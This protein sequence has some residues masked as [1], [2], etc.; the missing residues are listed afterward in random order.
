MPVCYLLRACTHA[1]TYRSCHLRCNVFHNLYLCHLRIMGAIVTFACRNWI[2]A[3]APHQ[4]C[5]LRVIFEVIP[6]VKL[7]VRRRVKRI[8][9]RSSQLKRS[10]LVVRIVQPVLL[11]C[12]SSEIAFAIFFLELPP[13]NGICCHRVPR[14]ILNSVYLAPKVSL[15]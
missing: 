1:R 2:V 5:H 14:V 13:G 9:P 3:F 7:K 11:I 4:S 10:V 15:F 12:S 8:S 6:V